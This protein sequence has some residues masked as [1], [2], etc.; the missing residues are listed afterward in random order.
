MKQPG[1]KRSVFITAQTEEILAARSRNRSAAVRQIAAGYHLMVAAL[2][3]RLGRFGLS[4]TKE[5]ST[6]WADI[7]VPERRALL[8]ALPPG[9][10]RA[11]FRSMNDADLIAVY[12]RTRRQ[13]DQAPRTR[14]R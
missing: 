6:A 4:H 14:K 12:D 1:V 13:Q 9:P 2:L 3:R 10:L 8:E 5:L 11:A 7:D